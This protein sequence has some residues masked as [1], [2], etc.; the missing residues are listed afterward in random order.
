MS[1]LAHAQ[2][3]LDA[4]G[5]KADSKEEM[6]A[7][8]R[9][10]ILQLVELFASQGHSGFSAGYA[11][12]C[13]TKLL[14][15]EP[16]APLSGEDS[17]WNDVAE[18]SGYPL[19]QNRRCSS[20]FKTNGEAYDI[21]G[22]VFYDILKDEETGEEFKSYFTNGTRTPVTFPYTPTTVYEPRRPEVEVICNESNNP[23]QGSTTE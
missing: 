3:E 9:R 12:A 14:K 17:E 22:V 6:D 20:V 11:I 10:D 1:L 16:L 13:I 4:I 21:N 7:Q 5:L 19:Y 15:F 18:E 2:N 23:P 8:M